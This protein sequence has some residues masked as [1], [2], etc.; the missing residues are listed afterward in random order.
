MYEDAEPVYLQIAQ[1]LRS[2]ILD[3]EYER[4]SRIPSE[5]QLCKLH[6]AN[7]GTIRRALD[8]LTAEGYL[9]R[10]RGKGTFVTSPAGRRMFWGFG[11]LSERLSGSG[12]TALATVLSSTVVYREN[13]P[14][15]R[16]R[17]LRGVGTRDGAY[18]VSV[19]TSFVPLDLMPDFDKEVFDDASL[20]AMMRDK[21]GRSPT[22]S[23][24]SLTPRLIDNTMRELL[25]E[26]PVQRSLLHATGQT[27]DQNGARIEESEITY[28][29]RVQ[30]VMQIDHVDGYAGPVSIP[31]R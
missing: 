2:K 26:S 23:I 12:D 7:R 6:I 31:E 11:S 14:T 21:Y 27:F 18:P 10:E 24:V 30:A 4:D 9:R 16:L 19:D 17:R 1:T 20:Y 5:N 22:R 8:I 3:G 29:S 28:S 25:Q 13:R 15:L